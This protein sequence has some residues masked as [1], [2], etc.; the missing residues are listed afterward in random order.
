MKRRTALEATVTAISVGTLAGCLG[1]GGTSNGSGSGSGGG[2]GGDATGTSSGTTSPSSDTANASSTSTGET[3]TSETTAANGTA[4]TANDTATTANSTTTTAG[5]SGQSPSIT[6]SQLDATGECSNP[7]NATVKSDGNGSSVTVTGCIRGPDGCAKPKLKSATVDEGTLRI[8]VTTKEEAG[9][10]TACTQQIVHLGY[11]VTVE[12]SGGRPKHVE[13][14]HE[15][16]GKKK[17]V[18]TDG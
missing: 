17:T 16:M 11:R 18:A 7:G 3:T 10:G 5:Q 4:T 6:S 12:L 13:V 15:T 14:V 1:G 2:S 8:V 9:N